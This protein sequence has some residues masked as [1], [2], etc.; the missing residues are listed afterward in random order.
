MALLNGVNVQVGEKVKQC[1]TCGT[2]FSNHLSSCPHCG[3]QKYNV[4]ELER[5]DL[6][7]LEELER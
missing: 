3:G 6:E 7:E 1:A 4:K 2:I 5:R